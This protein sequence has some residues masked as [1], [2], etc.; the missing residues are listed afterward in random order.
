[1]CTEIGS[2][3]LGAGSKYIN[4]PSLR[5]HPPKELG[6]TAELPA[7]SK[8]DY[9]TQL[10]WDLRDLLSVDTGYTPEALQQQ[11]TLRS[12]TWLS[13]ALGPRESWLWFQQRIPRGLHFPFQGKNGVSGKGGSPYI[14]K[15]PKSSISFHKKNTLFTKQQQHLSTI[16]FRE[17]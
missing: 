9:F 6:V 1:M 3:F 10:S 7:C 11:E 5:C 4:T 16:S 8:Q 15:L 17:I 14:Q 2:D 13:T 12:S